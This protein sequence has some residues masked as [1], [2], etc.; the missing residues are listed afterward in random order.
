M[1]ALQV[2]G[3]QALI[4]ILAQADNQFETSTRL[5]E[6]RDATDRYVADQ[7]LAREN[8]RGR[9]E[10]QQEAIKQAGEMKRQGD[11]TMK[12]RWDA[13]SKEIEAMRAAQ[14]ARADDPEFIDKL[15]RR[16]QLSSTGEVPGKV[17]TETL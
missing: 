14:D 9:T 10:L 13:F 17:T 5:A 3:L 4:E 2:I 6:N 16:Y 7:N 12:A 11:P 8:A 1:N 15:K